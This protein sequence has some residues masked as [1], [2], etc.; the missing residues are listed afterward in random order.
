MAALTTLMPDGSPQTSV[1]WCDFDGTFVCV[2]TMKGFRKERN[3]RGTR[4]SRCSAMT[5]ASHCGTWRS[6]ARVEQMTEEGA[7]EHLDA[8]ASKY[9]GRP[10]RW[11]RLRGGPL[12]GEAR[13][14]CSAGSG[15][16]TS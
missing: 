1:V 6:V 12:R 16:A 4:E 14:R 10:T 2:N 15:P 3:M 8:L 11:G 7:L 5:P 9:A 13:C